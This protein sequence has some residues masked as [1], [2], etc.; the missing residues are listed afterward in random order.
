[1]RVKLNHVVGEIDSLP[2]CTQVGVSHSVFLPEAKRGL[3]L[4]DHANKM[5]LD[6]MRD[7]L[8]YDYALCTVDVKNTAQLSVL[9]KNG[10]V[11]LSSFSSS[12]TGN[13]VAIYGKDLKF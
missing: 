9:N 10:W 5:R 13:T 3:G 7:E 2:G 12:K 6:L 4:G 8:G 11:R 1:M